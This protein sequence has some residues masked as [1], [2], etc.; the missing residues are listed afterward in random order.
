MVTTEL[1]INN[2]DALTGIARMRPDP[3]IPVVLPPC[4]EEATPTEVKEDEEEE[5]ED[6]PPLISQDD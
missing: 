5:I 2:V 3:V 1:I 6:T 4:N